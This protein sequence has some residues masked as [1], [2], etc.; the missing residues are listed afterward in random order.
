MHNDD[1]DDG[2]NAIGRDC[3]IVSRLWFKILTT[4]RQQDLGPYELYKNMI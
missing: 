4:A 3:H 1:D 2:N